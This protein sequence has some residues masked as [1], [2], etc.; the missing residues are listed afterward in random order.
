MA[1]WKNE[2]EGKLNSKLSEMVEM[3]AMQ[4]EQDQRAAEIASLEA[5]LARMAMTPTV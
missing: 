4:D 3:K 2:R 1:H 5:E